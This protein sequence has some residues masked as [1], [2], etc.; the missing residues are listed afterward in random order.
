[1]MV[2]RSDQKS[3][4][5]KEL[6]VTSQQELACLKIQLEAKVEHTNTCGRRW[7]QQCR[8]GGFPT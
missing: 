1:M 2:M 3:L 4:R 5:D 6:L 7:L 8:K